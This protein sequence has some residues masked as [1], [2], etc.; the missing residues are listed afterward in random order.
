MPIKRFLLFGCVGTKDTK[1]KNQQC[2]AYED[3]KNKH[4][5]G[6][7][8]PSR[9][10]HANTKTK[11]TFLQDRDAC[12]H[13]KK[14][15]RSPSDSPTAHA[16]LSLILPAHFL[17]R[18]QQQQHP[19]TF[20]IGREKEEREREMIKGWKKKKGKEAA[21]GSLSGF[22]TSPPL[23]HS[24]VKKTAPLS[25]RKGRKIT[26]FFTWGGGQRKCQSPFIHS[27][28]YHC[29]ANPSWQ[30]GVWREEVGGDI[31]AK[32]AVACPQQKCW[33]GGETKILA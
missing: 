17:L 16:S 21:K 32:T 30:I 24:R 14:K 22:H 6:A 8:I 18:W 12:E 28:I 11:R 15:K 25:Q 1:E 3:N 27:Q 9:L 23:L 10:I 7:V 29:L 31:N 5:C 13:G 19:F 4:F 2:T 26:P 20:I 33:G